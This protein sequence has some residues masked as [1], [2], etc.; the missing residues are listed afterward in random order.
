M[1]K[2]NETVSKGKYS[3]T[4]Q[5]PFNDGDE[6]KVV[7]KK[8]GYVNSE[9]TATAG[10][11]TSGL[12]KAIEKGTTDLAKRNE[13]T[14]ADKDLEA[15]IKEGEDL[16]TRTKPAP[17]TQN[18]IDAAK[19]RIEKAIEGK[20]KT[21]DARDRLK[22]KIKEAED[23]KKEPDYKTKPDYV[24]KE[25][26]ESA[27]DGT[28]VD[29]DKTSNK[30]SIENAIKKIQEKIDQYHKQQIGVNIDK[31]R[32][33]DQTIVLSV[34]ARNAKVE[35][36]K[37]EIDYNTWQ[38]VLTPIGEN[39]DITRLLV[40][41]LKETLPKGTNLFIKVTHPDYLSYEGNITVE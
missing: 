39:T 13:G 37:S 17:A 23:L 24:K 10:V 2:E 5:T 11:D 26:D 19:D 38:T 8:T 36:F 41:S 28:N 9:A 12:D 6:I 7:A 31:V 33:N 35:V 32:S 16:K 14:Q 27:K 22:E 40:V 3:F 30:E 34:T 20:K 21:D 18:E 4:N 25:L 15:A 29:N 1:I